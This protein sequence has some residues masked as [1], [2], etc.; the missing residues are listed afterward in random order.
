VRFPKCLI[1]R[2]KQALKLS[3]RNARHSRGNYISTS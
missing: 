2:K 1:W 3:P